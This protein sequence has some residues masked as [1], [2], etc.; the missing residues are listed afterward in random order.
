MKN[1]LKSTSQIVWV[2]VLII[3]VTVGAIKFHHP[4][5][6]YM[7]YDNFGTYNYLPGLIIYNDLGWKNFETLE[8]INEKYYCTST[9]Y[10]FHKAE[11]GYWI[12]RFT[13]G[14]SMLFSPFFL[15]GHTIALNTDYPADGFSRPY[16]LALF[17]GGFVYFLIGLFFMARVLSRL[18]TPLV[19]ATTL[20]AVYLGSNLLFFA[21]F[22]ND[23]P[24]VYLFSLYAVLI[25]YTIK[26]H[27]TP[28]KKYAA[29]IGIVL[30]V[31]IIARPIELFAVLIPLFWNVWNKESLI[32]KIELVK[33]HFS[34]FLILALM[35]FLIGLPQIIYW[36]IYTGSFF[37]SPMTDPAFGFDFL[38]PYFGWALFGFRKGL[39]IYAPIII[40]AYTG[41]YLLYRRKKEIF[42]P[43]FLFVLL[44]TYLL[45]SFSGLISYGWRAFIQ[46]YA[47][48]TIPLGFTIQYLFEKKLVVRMLTL[49]I[50]IAFIALTAFQSWQ[51]TKGI[52]HGSRMTKAYYFAV[53]GK[54]QV[55][56]ELKRLLLVERSAAAEE[57]FTDEAGYSR[58]V[59]Y[60]NDFEEIMPNYARY[61]DSVVA[62]SGRYAFR[63]D[64]TLPFSPGLRKSFRD[65]TKKDHAWIRAGVWVYPTA[66][67]AEHEA[68]LT[69]TFDHNGQNYKYRNTSIKSEN[70]DIKLNEWNYI[71]LDYLT[72]EPRRKND[73]LLVYIWYRGK[74]PIYFDDFKVEVFEP[75]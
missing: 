58:R 36:K 31:M 12:N 20:I 52:L 73:E 24:H 18:F 67:P 70:L 49:A 14:M 21:A 54:T 39:F 48:L 8:K 35:M 46:S 1:Y 22:G 41:L 66:D 75:K 29:I 62:L 57:H 19:A 74:A 3:A 59:A 37:F 30:G 53:F 7:A 71:S 13:M 43:V 28:L 45:S 10:Q 38:T 5:R 55:D 23:S 61:Y 2:A 56:P 26:W 15:I 40:F 27:D 50:I 11:T 34:H 9:W 32:Q 68:M 64:S 17:W 60:F 63:M 33:Q 51:L 69:I 6:N 25:W 65:L 72:P 16:Q 4:Q 42:W 47:V 44:N